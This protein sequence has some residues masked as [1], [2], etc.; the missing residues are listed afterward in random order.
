[1]TGLN[2]PPTQQHEHPNAALVR[3]LYDML[4]AGD[5]AGYLALIGDDAIFHVGGE[6]IV[7]G[8]YVGKD[9]IAGL[10]LKAFEETGGTWRTDLLEGAGKRHARHDA[11][12]LERAT[13]RP[14]HRNGQLQRLPGRQRQGRRALGVHRRPRRSRHL[15]GTL[16]PNPKGFCASNQ[17]SVWL[18]A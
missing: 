8:E 14:H 12:S 9:A 3:H 1:L 10:G 7:S 18:P 15:L 11:A 4:A 13:A 5:V 17:R 6:S 16:N 2:E